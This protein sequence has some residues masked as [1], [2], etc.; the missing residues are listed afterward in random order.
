MCTRR[1]I[2]SCPKC[3]PS[4][5]SH[6]DENGWRGKTEHHWQGVTRA[7]LGESPKPCLQQIDPRLAMLEPWD[8]KTQNVLFQRLLS[9]LLLRRLR[10]LSGSFDDDAAQQSLA[11]RLQAQASTGSQWE[12]RPIWVKETSASVLE[13]CIILIRDKKYRM[14]SIAA[15]KST[16]NIFCKCAS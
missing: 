7:T 5:L 10:Q 1:K 15:D 13:M 2:L 12:N 14:R 3:C 16:P 6:L 9:H 4:G 8:C 11:S